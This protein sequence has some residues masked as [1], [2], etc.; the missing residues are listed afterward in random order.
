[1]LGL[2]VAG[3]FGA[4]LSNLDAS[5]NQG[6][7]ILVRNFYL[8]VINPQCSEKKLLIISKLSTAAFG[9]VIIGLGLIV[10]NLRTLPLFDLLNQLGVALWLPLAVPMCLGLFYK[11]TPPWSSWST[12]LIGLTM[13]FL[14]SFVVKPSLVAWIPALHGPFKPEE[15]T[16]FTLFA[17][18]AFV[19][20]ACVAWFFFTTLFYESSSAEYKANVEEFFKRLETPIEE[21]TEEQTKENH[22]IVGAIG[23]LC[24]TFG[25]FVL[26][27]TAVPNPLTGR[28][29]FLFCGGTIFLAGAL[30]RM[31]SKRIETGR[32]PTLQSVV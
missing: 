26:I 28:L 23:R 7:G 25:G 3:I 31:A 29:A 32:A 17:T 21:L 6:V 27:M 20:I 2:L 24:C 12:V 19:A 10:S 1:M 15:V 8:P 18:V 5:V 9:L 30:L 14:A 22:L 13:S 16:Q 4:T 11:R